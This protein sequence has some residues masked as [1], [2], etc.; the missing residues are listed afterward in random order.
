MKIFAVL[1]VAIGASVASGALAFEVIKQGAH[2]RHLQGDDQQPDQ[3]E[4]PEQPLT[5]PALQQPG[6]P[7]GVSNMGGGYTTGDI[8]N[9]M[10]GSNEIVLGRCVRG[11]L[12]WPRCCVRGSS[13]W[14]GCRFYRCFPGSPIYPRCTLYGV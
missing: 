1:L 14:P 7:S 9:I 8:T 6:V 4:Q 2:L 12:N 3:P 5:Q 13:F 11:S 10:G